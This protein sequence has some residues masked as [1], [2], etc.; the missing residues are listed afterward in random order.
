MGTSFFDPDDWTPELEA[1][2]S[3]MPR[4][5]DDI[6]AEVEAFAK[7]LAAMPSAQG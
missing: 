2:F 1:E 7:Y 5:M 6:D 3:D 4:T